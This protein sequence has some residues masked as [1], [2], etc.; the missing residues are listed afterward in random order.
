MCYLELVNTL[1]HNL[2]LISRETEQINVAYLLNCVALWLFFV[3]EAGLAAR[4]V[5]DRHFD[6]KKA[7]ALLQGPTSIVVFVI[8]VFVRN[9]RNLDLLEFGIAFFGILSEVF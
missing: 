1:Y 2:L 5:L 4:G 9:V 3:C 7:P 8:R 6:N